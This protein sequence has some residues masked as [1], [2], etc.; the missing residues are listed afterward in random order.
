MT[1]SRCGRSGAMTR[2]VLQ[3]AVRRCA[4][5]PT[6]LWTIHVNEVVRIHLVISRYLSHENIPTLG[7]QS[8][9]SKLRRKNPQSPVWAK[10]GPKLRIQAYLFYWKLTNSTCS[11]YIGAAFVCQWYLGKQSCWFHTLAFVLPNFEKEFC[12]CV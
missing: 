8:I 5:L 11:K 1:R 10:V 2:R 4:F 6:I 3:P 12:R 9:T 7:Q